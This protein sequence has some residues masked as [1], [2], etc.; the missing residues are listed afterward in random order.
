MINLIEKLGNK[1]IITDLGMIDDPLVFS[2]NHASNPD[3]SWDTTIEWSAD[4]G[5]DLSDIP[6]NFHTAIRKAI[7]VHGHDH[8]PSQTFAVHANHGLLKPGE[9]FRA[10][11]VHIDAI[12]RSFPHTDYPNNDVFVVSDALPTIFYNQS[13]VLPDRIVGNV[14]EELHQIINE[15]LDEKS[16]F[17]LPP[18]H[19]ARFDS[20][21]VHTAQKPTEPTRRSFLMVRF[22]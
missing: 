4:K 11:G 21:A 9:I 16:G 19:M 17:T 14:Q 18:Y 6:A 10:W 1:P 20:F 13:F 22:F 5:Y 12:V 8:P 7:A 2:F 15:Q 3:G